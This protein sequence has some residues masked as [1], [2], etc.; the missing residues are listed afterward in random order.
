MDL[1]T[2]HSQVATPTHVCPCIVHV[3]V[4]LVKNADQ[5]L[6]GLHPEFVY[7]DL[8][9]AVRGDLD[10]VLEPVE[11]LGRRG[12]PGGVADEVYGVPFLHELRALHEDR[13]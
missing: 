12:G 10:A 1:E 4:L 6:G 13:C 7:R 11:V 2:G 9:P 8:L 3:T 5:R